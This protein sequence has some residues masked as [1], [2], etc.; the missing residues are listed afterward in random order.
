MYDLKTTLFVTDLDGTLLHSDTSLSDFTADTL[1]RLID[2]G[3][4]LSFAT[5]RSLYTAGGLVAKIAPSVPIILHNGVFIQKRSGEYLTKALFSADEL[6]RIIRTL[7]EYKIAPIVYSLIGGR[8][9]FS[10]VYEMLTGEARNFIVQHRGDPRDRPLSDPAGLY[11]GEVYYFTCIGRGEAL[12]CAYERLGEGFTRIL[13][14]DFYSGDDWLEL[15][16]SEASKASA[17]QRLKDLL[18]C[19]RI[20]AFGDGDNDISM[21]RVADE[22]CA[23]A[24][25]VPGLKAIADRIIGSNDEDG[26]A[27][28]LREY[29]L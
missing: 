28:F 29:L 6:E 14:R 1:N 2:R 8:E 19:E 4:K 18:G 3:A 27:A 26:V 16:P 23:V 12:K 24:N 10:Y 22:G 20:V 11:D 13:T 7:D 25:A 9:H 15:L 17:V 5:A 21:F